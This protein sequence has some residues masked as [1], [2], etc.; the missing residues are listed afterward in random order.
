MDDLA[1]VL[2]Y[3]KEMTILGHIGALLHWDQDTYMPKQ[4]IQARAEQSAHL[5]KLLHEKITADE[6]Y[7]AVERLRKKKLSNEHTIMIKKLHKQ[8]IKSRKIPPAFVEELSKT[9]SLA[10]AAWMQAR[11]KKDYNI[12]EPHLH[13]IIQL[14][15]KEVEYTKEPGH[16]YNTLLDDY[17][18]GMT[19][20]KITP[21]FEHLK[22]G[23]ITLIHHIESSKTYKNQKIIHLKKN[24]PKDKQQELVNDVIQRIGLG[25]EFSRVDFS[26]HPFSTKIGLHD[27]RITTNIRNDPL[28]AFRSSIHES[29][30]ALYESNMPEHHFY[31]VLGRDASIGLHE[32]QSRFWENMIGLRTPFWNFYFPKFQKTF[33]LTNDFT[34]WMHEVNMIKNEPI[35]IESD[36]VHYPL[37]IILR[38]ELEKGLIDGSVT[39]KKL[40]KLWNQKMQEYFGIK[41]RNDKEGV[42]QDIHWSLGAFGYFPTYIIGTIYAAQLYQ[43]LL[44]KYPSIE[45]DIAKGN[46]TTIR[47]WLQKNIHQYGALYLADDLIKKTCGQGLNPQTYLDYLTKKYKTLYKF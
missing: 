32:S 42:L 7:H 20:E 44:K 11:Q 37:H 1:L 13:K 19:V 31:N 28:F 6:F 24:Y 47:T 27:V 10:Q 40:N 30:H 15:R 33:E 46:Y 34:Q 2:A 17:E 39:T 25:K 21:L 12:F 9:V 26:E 36:E 16:P 35:R 29:G 22:Q 14:K 45:K 18:E 8:I 41:V 43:T 23:L 3:Q 4:G 38:F 5:S